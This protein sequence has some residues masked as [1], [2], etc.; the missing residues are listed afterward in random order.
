VGANGSS[1]TSVALP[2]G[3]AACP[4]GGA[5]FTSAS[6]TTA[7]CN[8]TALAYAS[9]NLSGT[10]ASNRNVIDDSAVAPGAYCFRLGTTPAVGVASVRGDAPSVGFAQVLIPAGS[11][12][13]ASGNTTAEVLT[14]GP[15]GAATD[16]PF[17]VMFN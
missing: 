2:V 5:S 13:T 9:V 10:L 11:A 14:F 6:G 12:C 7:A 3:S 8:G 4:A 15:T 1:V 16:L 17:D